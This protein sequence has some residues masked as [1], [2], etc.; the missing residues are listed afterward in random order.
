MSMLTTSLKEGF[1]T[2]SASTTA[3]KSYR[4]DFSTIFN[5]EVI[6]DW[7]SF[8]H[9]FDIGNP[10]NAIDSGRTLKLTQEG[11]IEWEKQD[12]TQIR[13]P[14]SDTSI[15]V[16]CDGQHLWFQGNI[17]RFQEKDNKEG[18]TVIQ[19][20][21]KAAN[22]LRNI[23]PSLDLRLLG[24]IQ[25]EGTISEYGTYLTRIDLASNFH[26]DSYLQLSQLFASRK[27]NRK[28]PRVGKYGPTWGYEAKRGQYWKAKLYDKD[29][30]L[31]GKHTPHTHETTARFEIQLGSEYLRQN[32]L[33]KLL[34]WSES[35]KTE[36]IIYGKF[37]NQLIKEPATI[38]D[39]Y[40]FPI[41]LRQHAIMWKDGVDPK[42]YLSKA[43]YY[44]VRNKLLVYGLDISSPCNIMTLTQR[45]KTITLTQLPTLRRVA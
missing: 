8:R 28:L 22:L 23:Y 12:F 20:F 43:Q 32:K 15:R 39:F 42:S 11:V 7:L 38:Q 1:Q 10:T 16:K 34:A 14:S 5:G 26:T 33:N 37:A 19:C 9:D 40:D 44:Q 29:A 45:V 30:E 36:N 25:R 27:I 41:K 2:C 18:L 17:G 35:M 31:L 3:S 4:Q 21:E 24:S 13:C 6:C